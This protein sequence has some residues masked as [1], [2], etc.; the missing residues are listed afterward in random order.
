MMG[1]LLSNLDNSLQ[2]SFERCQRPLGVADRRPRIERQPCHP[3]C[4][5]GL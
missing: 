4:I 5:D 1:A 3:N 2:P